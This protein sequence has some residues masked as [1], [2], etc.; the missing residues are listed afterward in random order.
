L[1]AVRAV[2]SLFYDTDSRI[3]RLPQSAETRRVL[4]QQVLQQLGTL[5]KEAGGDSALLHEIAYCYTQ[6]ARSQG[7]SPYSV[8]DYRGALQSFQRALPLALRAAQLRGEHRYQELLANVY[9]GLAGTANWVGE[10][11]TAYR[12]ATEGQVRLQKQ[13]DQFARLGREEFVTYNLLMLGTLR[14]ETLAAL[15]R[16]EEARSAWLEADKLTLQY[17]QQPPRAYQVLA[18]IISLKRDLAD[19]YCTLGNSDT[20]MGYATSAATWEKAYSQQ[21]PNNPGLTHQV[22][23][24]IGECDLAA[25]R[26]GPAMAAFRRSVSFYRDQW[27][28]DPKNLESGLSVVHGQQL[29][30]RSLLESGQSQSAIGVYKQALDLFAS[31]ADLQ[32]SARAVNIRGQLLFGLASAEWK[33]AERFP[34]L[35]PAS[36]Q[37]RKSAC[38]NYRGAQAVLER[39]K[40]GG[41]WVG[42]RLA[43][44]QIEEAMAACD[45]AH[46]KAARVY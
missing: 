15:G 28:R 39:L 12:V 25:R 1:E 31:L 43:L 36:M 19:H 29:E 20:G 35:S 34:P 23:I 21:Q 41:L 30:G 33:Q 18:A 9:Q 44:Q 42:S 24:V 11:D 46:A 26:T 6:L 27:N 32:N 14:G 2:R 37:H 3:S 5:E 4:V 13:Y 8:G 38:D 17:V 45:A 22:E 10:Y 16:M 7:W 40:S